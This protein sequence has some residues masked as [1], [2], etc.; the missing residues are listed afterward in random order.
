MEEKAEQ[1]PK[2][3][4]KQRVEAD[5]SADDV[6]SCDEYESAVAQLKEEVCKK[7]PKS[8]T[9]RKLL[10][11]TFSSRHR[12]I[13]QEQPHVK[14]IVEKFPFFND[15]R[16]VCLNFSMHKPSCLSLQDVSLCTKYSSDGNL[17]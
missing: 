16:W 12:W 1:P 4:K 15:E 2:P 7:H 8:K 6:Q 10:E 9:V 17:Q 5:L 11:K 13:T 3:A 14:E